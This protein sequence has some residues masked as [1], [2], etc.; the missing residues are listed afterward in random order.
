MTDCLEP[1][2]DDF[3]PSADFD[4]PSRPEHKALSSVNWDFPDR[5][6]HSEIEG[7]H[8]AK[9][10]AELPRAVLEC[11]PVQPRNGCP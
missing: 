4:L 6:A 1:L 9:F 2:A 8:P 3:S 10:V 5:I 7:V 11:L